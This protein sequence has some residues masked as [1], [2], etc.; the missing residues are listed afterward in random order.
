MSIFFENF[1]TQNGGVMSR[2][3]LLGKLLLCTILGLFATIST[4]S[5]QCCRGNG[6]DSNYYGRPTTN[7]NNYTYNY[8]GTPC[9]PCDKKKTHKSF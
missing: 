9:N 8:N 7:W 2:H 1:T 6:G 3:V 5:A 4:L